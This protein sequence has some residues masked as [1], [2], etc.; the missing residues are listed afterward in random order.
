MDRST[1]SFLRAFVLGSMLSV[2][3]PLL[4]TQPKTIRV[5]QD[6]ATIQ[7][8]IDAAVHGDTVLV[9]EGTYQVNL[10]LTKQIT[11]ASQY[12][13]D[14]DPAHITQT[15]LDGSTPADTNAASVI[16]ISGGSSL[17]TVVTGFTIRGGKGTRFLPSTS[18]WWR[19]GGGICIAAGGAS[20]RNNV[21]RDNVV[22]SGTDGADGGAIG[23]WPYEG[24]IN[25]WV[26][27]DNMIVNNRAVTTST[28][29]AAEGGGVYAFGSGLFTGNS[30]D[31]NA[32]DGIVNGR[33]GGLLLASANGYDV[34]TVTVRNNRFR[35][36]T[37]HRVGG[38]I[39]VW[40][41]S[42][43]V[44]NAS[45]VNN[46]VVKNTSTIN[47][48]AFFINTYSNVTLINNTVA[49][50]HTGNTS[51]GLIAWGVSEISSHPIVSGINNIFWNPGSFVNEIWGVDWNSFHHNLIRGVSLHGTDNFSADPQ[52]VPDGSYRLGSNSPCVGAGIMDMT[53]HGQALVAPSTDL[54]G[55]PL[56]Q[57]AGTLP[58][59]GAIQS[60]EASSTVLR[61]NRAEARR[62]VHGGIWRWYGVVRPLGREHEAGRPVLIW[63]PGYGGTADGD[64]NYFQHYLSA[65]SA[66]FFTVYAEGHQRRWNS[67]I[68]TGSDYQTPTVDDVGYLSSL[69]DTLRAH[70]AI[71]TNRV[72]VAG[73][74]NGGFMAY[75]LAARLSH[76]LAGIVS[77]GARLPNSAALEYA[78]SA[79]I[80]MMIA[81]GT[82]DATVGYDGAHANWWTVTSTV[83]FWRDKNN[84]ASMSE[85]QT[86][87]AVA[88]DGTSITRSV[89]GADLPWNVRGVRPEV[90]FYRID[91]GGHEWPG[92][93]PYYGSGTISRELTLNTEMFRFFAATTAPDVVV[94]PPRADFGNI[95]TS[96]VDSVVLEVT[97][98]GR[99][100]F[101]LTAIQPLRSEFA[102]ST[103]PTL[104][105]SL[106]VRASVRV[107][108]VFQ[109]TTQGRYLDTL[110]FNTTD[111]VLAGRLV[112]VVGRAIDSVRGISSG[113]AYVLER[114]DDDRALLRLSIPGM[115][116]T[117]LGTAGLPSLRTLT[118]D[119]E[120]REL[121]GAGQHLGV[122][123][124]YRVSADSGASVRSRSLIGAFELVALACG[125]GDTLYGVTS[126]GEIRRIDRTTG[127]STILRGPTADMVFTAAAFDAV[128]GHLWLA[129]RF[130]NNSLFRYHP[131]TGAFQAVAGLPFSSPVV[132]MASDAQ[133]RLFTLLDNGAGE[134]YLATVS[135]AT[136]DA[137]AVS[138]Q[139]IGAS[140]LMALAVDPNIT[141]VSSEPS[142]PTAFAL[143]QNFPN[144]FNPSTTIRFALARESHVR[145]TVYNLLGQ[146]V[147]ELVNERLT[148]GMKQV[149]WTAAVP[150]SVY[151]YTLEA[152]DGAGHRFRET[153]RMML[154]K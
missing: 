57:P 30:V 86:F 9:A 114:R 116:T 150:S 23:M 56:P 148:P 142:T 16:R 152:D 91:N 22:Q 41:A 92:A 102:L 83:Q 149:T 121:L 147:H 100:D 132:G 138:D 82:A 113:A 141:S 1:L 87:N 25:G 119:P 60:T 84:A 131:T 7:G 76:R 17:A 65:D 120:R 143:E 28:V 61:T 94:S 129:G 93:P 117:F 128:G 137:T 106:S 130:P 146:S 34:P 107:R 43:A 62:F 14:K 51:D 69:I 111:A 46:L 18:Q 153:K 118:I 35:Y 98:W 2:L 38:A 45:F 53:V 77:V 74:S 154:L 39:Y 24:S 85:Q 127:S 37:A 58:D 89:Y 64:L 70:Y 140:N 21:L 81:N 123:H 151:L 122:P 48:G 80:P 112:P 59:L 95:L 105:V 103:V 96:T 101:S 135:T 139:P 50:N 31:S 66:G 33:A 75:R 36:N 44:M 26:I 29:F 133:G 47:G 12:L 90:W 3:C 134:F 124:L 68:T 115:Q 27:S 78:T 97:N 42:A 49:D 11:L 19:M 99:P 125:R 10:V 52:F 144:P 136:G 126:V 40:G 108:V 55:A 15:I 67:G 32:V 109:P 110:R 5:P 104:P 72:Y 63:L 54:L 79:R 73:F 13:I 71:D 20:I 4:F 145:L 6:Q 88:G 8:A